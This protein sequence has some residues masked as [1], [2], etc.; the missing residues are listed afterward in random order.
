M[1]G[2]RRCRHDSANGRE[3][4]V[5]AGRD[6]AGI[7]GC[8]LAELRVYKQRRGQA[9]VEHSGETREREK[10]KDSPLILCFLTRVSGARDVVLSFDR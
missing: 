2:S 10:K 3:A 1:D 9:D 7:A 8:R 4:L 6:P 5:P